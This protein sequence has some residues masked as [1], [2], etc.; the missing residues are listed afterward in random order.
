VIEAAKP[1]ETGSDIYMGVGGAAEGVLAAA[2]LC[3]I[4]GQFLGRL[5][6]LN[7]E[8]RRRAASMGIT[9]LR[10]IYTLED[11]VRGDVIFSATGITD[12]TMLDGV[13]FNGKT[14]ETHSIVM[15]STSKTV[16]WVHSCY[17]V[18]ASA[19]ASA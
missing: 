9:D 18:A 19:I 7:D 4:G 2:A 14:V 12:G 17:D 1:A 5:T 13:K 16:R 10:K 11:M 3:S 6:P 8:Q 15:R